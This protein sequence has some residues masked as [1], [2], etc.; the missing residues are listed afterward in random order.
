MYARLREFSGFA[1]ILIGIVAGPLPVIPG[2][3]LIMAGMALVGKDHRLIR[4]CR[5]WLEKHVVLTRSR[6]KRN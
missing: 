3:P 2:I 5:V 6:A 1:L 4:P